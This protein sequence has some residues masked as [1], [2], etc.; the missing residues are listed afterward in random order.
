[1]IVVRKNYYCFLYL[2]INTFDACTFQAAKRYE[3][4]SHKCAHLEFAD[5]AHR[6]PPEYF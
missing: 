6:Q 1:M 5:Q 4:E 3:I 2:A